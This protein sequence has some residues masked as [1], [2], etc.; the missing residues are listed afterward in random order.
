VANIFGLLYKGEAAVSPL[1]RLALIA[2]LG[3]MSMTEK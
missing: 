3:R 2:H 1:R